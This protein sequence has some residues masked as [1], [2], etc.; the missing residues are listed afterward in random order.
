MPGALQPGADDL[1]APGLD[2]ARGDA[3]A[4][5]AEPR[6]AHPAAVAYD[7]VEAPARRVWSCWTSHA[8]KN[9]DTSLRAPSGKSRAV[10][11]KTLVPAHDNVIARTR[12]PS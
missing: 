5:G 9:P 2:H 8:F 1:L 6:I 3:Q 12:S 11:R 7:V 10:P 4:L